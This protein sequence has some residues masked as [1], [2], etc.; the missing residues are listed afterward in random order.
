MKNKKVC[1][2]QEKKKSFDF[3]EEEEKKFVSDKK[4]LRLLFERQFFS[5]DSDYLIKFPWKKWMSKQE[6]LL[7]FDDSHLLYAKYGF[8]EKK[9]S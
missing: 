5:T 4:W 6:K 3:Q 8:V 1:Q 9:F 7:N 2:H